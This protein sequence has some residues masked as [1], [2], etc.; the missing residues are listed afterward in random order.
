M[1]T[2]IDLRRGAVLYSPRCEMAVGDRWEVEMSSLSGHGCQDVKGDCVFH[3]ST[4][5]DGKVAVTGCRVSEEDWVAAKLD[6]RYKIMGNPGDPFLLR[7]NKSVIVGHL[8][9]TV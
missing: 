9:R 7:L 4:L 1:G 3:I 2:N 8:R 5:M 6:L